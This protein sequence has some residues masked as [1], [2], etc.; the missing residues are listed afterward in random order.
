M[1]QKMRETSMLYLPRPDFQVGMGMK[2]WTRYGGRLTISM[3]SRK[4][5]ATLYPYLG[6]KV[7]AEGLNATAILSL[8]GAVAVMGGWIYI[9]LKPTEAPKLPE[10]FRSSSVTAIPTLQ[11]TYLYHDF[12]IV[13]ITPGASRA[14]VVVGPL[15]TGTK[16]PGRM[17][18]TV[19]S[20]TPTPLPT[21]T[22]VVLTS[23]PEVIIRLFVPPPGVI[24]C[25]PS[26][27]KQDPC[28]AESRPDLYWGAATE[29]A[30]G[31]RTLVAPPPFVTFTPTVPPTITPTFTPTPSP[32]LTPSMMPIAITATAAA[33]FFNYGALPLPL[34]RHGGPLRRMP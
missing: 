20:M 27:G 5:L 25:T 6:I 26:F 12:Q 17:V 16:Q 7:G 23:E 30:I 28:Y 15:P 2:S 9:A 31:Y 8:V 34:A 29:I 10:K 22:P 33:R 32:T 13:E 24:I 19:P 1:G 4:N 18:T 21:L 11:P 3:K 14:A